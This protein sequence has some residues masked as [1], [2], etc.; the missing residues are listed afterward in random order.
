M[1]LLFAFSA[2]RPALGLAELARQV[3]LSKSTAAA[4]SSRWSGT[5]W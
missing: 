4:C 2:E 5:A 1:R 3:G